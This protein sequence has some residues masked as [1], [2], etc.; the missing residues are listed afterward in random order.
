VPLFIQWEG[1]PHPSDSSATGCTLEKFW[2]EH[3]DAGGLAELYSALSIAVDVVRRAGLPAL[4]L[5]MNAPK[6]VVTF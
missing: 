2:V 6:G 4:K 3:P 1:A 5:T